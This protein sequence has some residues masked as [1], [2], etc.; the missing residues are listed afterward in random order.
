VD[1]GAFTLEETM[2]NARAVVYAATA[3]G[4]V[5]S[6]AACGGSGSPSIPAGPLQ[7]SAASTLGSRFAQPNLAPHALYVSDAIGKSVFR[8]ALNGDGTLKTPAGSSLVLPYNPGAI[9]IGPAGKLFVVSLVNNSIIVYPKGACCDDKPL[10]HIAL[11]FQPTSVAVDSKGYVYVGGSTT[12]YVAVFTPNAIRRA[13]PIQVISLPDRHPTVNGVA[14]DAAGNLYMSD[15]NEISV[16]ATPTTNPTLVRAIIGNGQQA[17]PSGMAFDSSNE[18]YATNPGFQNIL[19]YSP[20]A[21]GTDPADRLIS[22]NPA[23]IGD[24]SDAVLGTTLYVN[25]GNQL[26]GPPSIVLLNTQVGGQQVPIQVVTGSYLALPVGV[27]L[28]P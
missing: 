19:A 22:S 3:A 2:H 16:F 21:N 20:T 13:K 5:L 10:K 6:L 8:F 12:G 14:V 1:R 4:A 15:T 23:L 9:A 25:S 7:N 24:S 27:A 28:G 18:L 26:F 11:N 17:A